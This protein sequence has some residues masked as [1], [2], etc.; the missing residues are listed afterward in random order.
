MGKT[1]VTLTEVQERILKY[2]L[3]KSGA[4]ACHPFGDGSLIIKVK[5]PS[6]ERT[7]I[8]VQLF[9]LHGEP[10]TTLNCDLMMGEFYRSL[11]TG[12]VVCGYHCP[13]VQQPYF[14]T[15][16]LDGSISEDEF[17][18]MSDHAYDAVVAKLPRYMHGELL[19]KK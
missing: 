15:I 19:M 4:F 5:A 12:K 8:F 18:R 6:H 1:A 10:M 17:L 9:E 16:C 7:R 13:P 11:Y 3:E 14:N 2:C